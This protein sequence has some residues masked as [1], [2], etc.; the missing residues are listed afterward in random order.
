MCLFP[1][2]EAVSFTELTQLNLTETTLMPFTDDKTGESPTLQLS[3]M[4]VVEIVIGCFIITLF[5]VTLA[6][7]MYLCHKAKMIHRSRNLHQQETNHP[8]YE[9]ISNSNKNT[10]SDGSLPALVAFHRNPAYALQRTQSVPEPRPVAPSRP[11]LQHQW[12]L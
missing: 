1:L 10:N 6:L 11:K 3:T 8:I 7:W 2:A 4:T 12:L 5:L 9:H